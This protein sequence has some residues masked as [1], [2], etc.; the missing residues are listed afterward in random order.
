M[1][2]LTESEFEYL[3]RSDLEQPLTRWCG[4]PDEIWIEL[5]K[6]DLADIEISANTDSHK[7]LYALIPTERGR[8]VLAEISPLRKMIYCVENGFK[9]NAQI[10]VDKLSKRELPAA[11]AS[12]N[13]W[14]RKEAISRMKE[15]LEQ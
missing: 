12:D 5:V 4:S 13:D 8:D 9:F 14:V 3:Y 1:G 6:K 7:P 10:L 11:L 15:L 2:E